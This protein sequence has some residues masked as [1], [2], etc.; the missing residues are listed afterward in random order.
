MTRI[1]QVMPNIDDKELKYITQSIQEGWLTEG[2]NS[3]EFIRHIKKFTGSKYAVLAPNGTLGLFLGLLALGLPRGSEVIVPSF[4]FFA[5]ASSVI[6][7]GL[8]PV[9]VDVD[10]ETFNIDCNKVES[11]ITDKTKAIMPVHIYGHSANMDKVMSIAEKYNLKVIEDAAQAYGVKY[12]NKHCGILGD[13]SVISF[14]ADKTITMGEGAVVLTQ[15]NKLYKKLLLLR[16]QGRV[17]SGTFVH[18]S[19]GMNFRVTDLQCGVGLAQAEKFPKI[20][21][22]KIESYN[23]YKKEL[24]GVGD[25]SFLKV[26]DNSSFVP[27]RFFIRTKYKDKLIEFLEGHSIQTRSFFYPMHQ[28]PPLIQYVPKYQNFPV[29][30]YLYKTGICLPLHMYITNEEITYIVE[31]IKLF[32]MKIQ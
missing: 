31:K 16:N 26:E 6:F 17:D 28:Q 30:E 27:F 23:K 19:I 22:R 3:Q 21:E 2:P 9:F 5:S 24:E 32:F 12:K 29:S 14:F 25:L 20:L 11:L 10:I 7:A 15:S 4:T 1:K 13:V 18:Q 8:R